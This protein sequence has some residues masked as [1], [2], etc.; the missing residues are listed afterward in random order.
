M[1]AKADQPAQLARHSRVTTLE[2]HL[3]DGG[4]GSWLTESVAGTPAA[5]RIEPI[6]L[7]PEICDMV[8]GQATLN[9]IGGLTL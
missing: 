6:A 9:R 7:S 2:D 4:F 5:A 1:A 3:A 8:A